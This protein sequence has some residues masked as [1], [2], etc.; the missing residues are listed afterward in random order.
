MYSS[1]VSQNPQFRELS[2]A[3]LFPELYFTGSAVSFPDGPAVLQL[4]NRAPVR[5][6]EHGAQALKL[7]PAEKFRIENSSYHDGTY[8]YN[9]IDS[10]GKIHGAID[11][12]VELDVLRI[13]GDMGLL[14]VSSHKVN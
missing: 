4:A 7:D 6:T 5:L 2:E 14:K 12:H 8:S 11:A 13:L 9:L 3:G 10:K 1:I